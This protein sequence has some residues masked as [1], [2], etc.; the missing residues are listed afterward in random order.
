MESKLLISEAQKKNLLK[1][2]PVEDPGPWKEETGWASACS[3]VRELQEG[4]DET[5]KC[6]LVL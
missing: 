3:L 4:A 1:K 2:M 6:V 5:G